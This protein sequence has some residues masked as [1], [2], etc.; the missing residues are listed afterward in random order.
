M[1]SQLLIVDTSSLR[2][3]AQTGTE[4]LDLLF[5]GN[6]RVVITEA[7]FVEM[8]RL[9]G[10]SPIGKAWREWYGRHFDASSPF[11]SKI[12]QIDDVPGVDLG[13]TNAGE[14]SIQIVMREAGSNADLK[15]QFAGFGV[16][17]DTVRFRFLIDELPAYN[18]EKNQTG[19]FKTDALDA[20]GQYESPYRGTGHFL[21]ELLAN[22]DIDANRHNQIANAIRNG[23]FWHTKNNYSTFFSEFYLS[24]EKANRFSIENTRKI[25]GDP[26][27]RILIP[28]SI[29]GVGLEFLRQVGV[30]GDILSFGVTAAHAADLKEQ[31]LED[32]ANKTWIRYI[33]ETS[34]GIA[35]GAIGAALGLAVGGPLAALVG[36]IVAGYAVGEYGAEFG[37]YVYENYKQVVLPGLEQLRV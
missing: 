20:N 13:N 8:Q 37:E 34:G 3:L 11:G 23:S 35:G 5:A 18:F 21:Q 14:R 6:K 2:Q 1:S 19:N 9:D 36:G 31:G 26:S 32:E 15:A 33:F 17:G 25:T 7:V 4:N 30:L 28:A 12:L 10:N 27:G 24:D 29:L 22:G 16:D